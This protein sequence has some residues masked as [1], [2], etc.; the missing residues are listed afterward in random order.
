MVL[1]RTFDALANQH[2]RM[3]VDRLTAGPLDTPALAC[4]FAISK[5]ALNRHL[6]VLEGTGLIERRLHGRVHE[7]TLHAAP[8]AGVSDW[9]AD[10]RRGWE[11]NFDR[12]DH[13]LRGAY[14]A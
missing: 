2:R 3:I 4:S 14:D 7:L 11:A 6:V 12:L 9:L 8:L 1:D 10:I 13:I 5:Q